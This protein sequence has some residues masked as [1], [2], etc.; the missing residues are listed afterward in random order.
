MGI[1]EGLIVYQLTINSEPHP[2]PLLNK[3]RERFTIGKARVRFHKL[4]NQSL[5]ACGE[6]NR[7]TFRCEYSGLLIKIGYSFFRL[8]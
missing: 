8:R 2:N 3:E 5:A 1:L 4:D 7:T 6:F